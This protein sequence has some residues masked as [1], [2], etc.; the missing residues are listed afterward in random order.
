MTGN[1]VV[2]LMAMVGATIE[3]NVFDGNAM[4]GLAIDA[5]GASVK[6]NTFSHSYPYPSGGGASWGLALLGKLVGGSCSNVDVRDNDF[7]FNGCA[8]AGRPECGAIVENGSD[9]ASIVFRNNNFIDLRASGAALALTS[10]AAGIVNAENNW[11]S[12][13]DGP[14]GRCRD[15]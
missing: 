3:D 8:T 10:E 15:H 14:C 2:W 7:N 6:N 13:A 5:D 12:S 11:W 9:A 1:G 4:Y